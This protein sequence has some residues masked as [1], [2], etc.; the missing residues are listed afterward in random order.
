MKRALFAG[1]VDV[2][3]LAA[4]CGCPHSVWFSGEVVRWCYGSPCFD[5]IH[6]REGGLLTSLDREARHNDF[7]HPT[8]LL[9]K[10]LGDLVWINIV[11]TFDAQGSPHLLV[12]FPSNEFGRRGWTWPP[13]DAHGE[14]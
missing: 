2:S 12:S 5:Y 10:A 9:A 4:A 6:S 1:F 14:S 7:D 13:R 11:K 8:L 3:D